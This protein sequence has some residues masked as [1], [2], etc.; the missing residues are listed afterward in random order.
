M[1]SVMLKFVCDGNIEDE[2]VELILNLV[3]TSDGMKFP[4]ELQIEIKRW[5]L[6]CKL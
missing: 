3:E 4:G 6:W 1:K 5:N 2:R